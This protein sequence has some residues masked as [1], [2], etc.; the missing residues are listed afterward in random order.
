MDSFYLLSEMFYLLWIFSIYCQRS[1]IYRRFILSTV[2]DRLSTVDAFYLLSEVGYLLWIFSIY[3]Q[4][5]A[6][7]CGSHL[8]FKY[9]QGVGENLPPLFF[10][11]SWE[12]IMLSDA[13]E[14][15]LHWLLYLLI[16]LTSFNSSHPIHCLFQSFFIWSSW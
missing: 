14:F 5:S 1:A 6:I 9:C 4:R 16:F 10:S 11:R 7:D 8:N 15:I 2:R 3:C 13:L 12:Y